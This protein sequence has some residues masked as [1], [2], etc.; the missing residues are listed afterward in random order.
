MPS[1]VAGKVIKLM[2][3]KGHVIKNSNILILGFTF[4]EN[5]PDTRNTKV[6]EIYSELIQYESNVDIYDPWANKQDVFSEY[7][8]NLQNHVDKQKIYH[9]V[10]IAVAHDEFKQFD[11]KKYKE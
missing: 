11:F 7:K 8:L 1:F 4:K 3:A 10:I 9:A 2:I 5:C 6:A